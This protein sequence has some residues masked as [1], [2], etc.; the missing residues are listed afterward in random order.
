MTDRPPIPP[1]T[2]TT[3]GG[4]PA[5]D[6][7][8]RL[9]ELRPHVVFPPA[10][11]LAASVRADLD[12][13]GSQIVTA[14]THPGR[15]WPDWRIALAA[16][17]AILVLLV[18]VLAV[19]PT[20]AAVAGWLDRIDLPGIRIEFTGDSAPPTEPAS[21]VGMTI[22]LG[23]RVS[24]T[25]AAAQAAFP[26]KVPSDATLGAPDEVYVRQ[27]EGGALVSL[28]YLPRPELPEIGTTGVGAL[29]MQFQSTQEVALMVKSVSE[30]EPPIPI[31]FGEG[32]GY[33]VR[34]GRLYIA[35]D[36]SAPPQFVPTGARPSGNVLLWAEGGVTYRLE[37]AI[38][39]A[40]AVVLAESLVTFPPTP[41]APA[42]RSDGDP[43]FND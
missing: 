34:N 31:R 33:W 37:T 43:N 13:R 27:V 38:D 3:P 32:Y 41:T 18:I 29:L 1:S 9:T 2:T 17:A 30:A 42:T 19:P 36:P 39:R 35:P 6:L 7:E 22:L 21:A 4:R 14:T 20:R 26:L 12:R 15:R 40:P 10:P 5:D 25:E 28:L 16:G 11:D 23:E 8:R 24:L